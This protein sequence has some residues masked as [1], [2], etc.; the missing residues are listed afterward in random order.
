[1]TTR[2]DVDVDRY[3]ARLAE[4]E[5]GVRADLEHLVRIPS[6]SAAAFDQRHVEASAQAVAELLRGVGMPEVEILRAARPDGTDGAPAVVARRPAPPG[7]PT[8][9]LYA[10]H[11]VQPPGNE[12]DWTAPPF[13]PTER[14]GRL[15]GR[16]TADDKAGVM[17][18]VAALRALLPEWAEHEGVG[19]TVFVEGEEEIGSPSFAE[20]LRTHRERLAA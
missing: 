4:L 15:F 17:A 14:D 19:I 3:R 6:V 9:L 13:E 12:N 16:G 10:H 2:T 8:V 1:M 5:D 7:A 18:H 11:D 20:F